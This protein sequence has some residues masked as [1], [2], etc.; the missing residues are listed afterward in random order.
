MVFDLILFK[1][2]RGIVIFPT[3]SKETVIVG[4]G[5]SRIKYHQNFDT[6]IIKLYI[7]NWYF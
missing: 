1:I 4:S 3:N 7:H 2:L 6:C 5:N